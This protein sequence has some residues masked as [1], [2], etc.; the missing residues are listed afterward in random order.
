MLLAMLLK[1]RRASSS[2]PPHPPILSVHPHVLACTR[3]LHP[4]VL[5]AQAEE[6]TA[7]LRATGA[8]DIKAAVAEARSEQ[9]DT[10]D[11]VGAALIVLCALPV[12]VAL[13]MLAADLHLAESSLVERARARLAVVNARL[14]QS[15]AAQRLRVMSAAARS[16][17]S[18]VWRE[19]AAVARSGSSSV[20]GEITATPKRV[21]HSVSGSPKPRHIVG[22]PAKPA[23]LT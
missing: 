21:R 20:W 15:E 6:L 23:L 12:P 10:E 17:S 18:D 5:A 7:V 8:Y 1:G 9:Q 11:A 14:S 3:A 16:K 22:C 19:V 2:S 4:S 13:A